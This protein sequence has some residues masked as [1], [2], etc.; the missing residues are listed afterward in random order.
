MK[1]DVVDGN[2]EIPCEDSR[3]KAALRFPEEFE[4]LLVHFSSGRSLAF[5]LFLAG[6]EFSKGAASSCL[7]LLLKLGDGLFDLSL[8]LGLGFPV[9]QKPSA[10]AEMNEDPAKFMRSQG[11][12]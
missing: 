10:V 2:L 7:N 8:F 5:L 4:F 6:E 12:V 9:A 1:D 11:L 3:M